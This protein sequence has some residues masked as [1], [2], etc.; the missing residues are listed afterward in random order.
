MRFLNDGRPLSA[1][2]AIRGVV[3]PDLAAAANGRSIMAPTPL[4]ASR[5]VVQIL[6]EQ[7]EMGIYDFVNDVYTKVDP[8][9]D[10]YAA[11]DENGVNVPPTGRGFDRIFAGGGVWA[12]NAIGA[13]RAR[14]VTDSLGRHWGPW[15]AAVAV[16]ATGQVLIT[17]RVL[18][19]GTSG[20]DGNSPVELWIFEPGDRADA[21][22]CRIAGGFDAQMVGSLVLW[23]DQNSAWHA[24]NTG[25]DGTLAGPRPDP[26][27][28]GALLVLSDGRKF[29]L[30]SSFG[31]DLGEWTD[32]SVVADGAVYSDGP[33]DF[34]PD[35]RE[36]APGVIEVATS[37]GAGENDDEWR[38]TRVIV[39]PPGA[40]ATSWTA[41]RTT[42]AGTG[43]AAAAWIGDIS[44]PP[45]PPDAP[46]S[47]IGSLGGP[48][49]IAY[50]EAITPAMHYGSIDLPTNAQYLSGMSFSDLF[51]P[52]PV[53][54]GVTE[55]ASVPDEFLIAIT[56]AISEGGSATDLGALNVA[57]DY[58]VSRRKPLALL[59]DAA[60]YCDRP[61]LVAIVQSLARP[62]LVVWFW[63]E[64]YALPGASRA[65][66]AARWDEESA[67]LTAL[68]VDFIVSGTAYTQTRPRA[69]GTPDPTV[70]YPLQL[71][72]DLQGDLADHHRKYIAAG[73]LKADLKFAGKRFGGLTTYPALMATVPQWAAS[74]T[75][76]TI[77]PVQSSSP[78]QPVSEDDNM[79]LQQLN[80]YEEGCA[81]IDLAV[82]YVW[83]NGN[84]DM[85][86][87]EKRRLA[88][89]YDNKFYSRD[90]V[91]ADLL[92]N[93][94]KWTP[95]LGAGTAGAPQ[96]AGKTVAQIVA[97]LPK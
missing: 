81:D 27:I 4:D 65:D 23:K 71:I 64:R 75:T 76:P 29:L 88:G 3:P 48:L 30:S 40:P 21:P 13:G 69:D 63:S 73:R 66:I 56:G 17:T 33:H 7:S 92:S 86:R 59:L 44:A 54:A 38:I 8:Q 97:G 49:W 20:D 41:T 32:G 2:G 47:A 1:H 24:Y 42:P 26:P 83:P 61:D 94:A 34:N 19:D 96:C 58:A 18:P 10:F 50:M 31:V 60:R 37:Y 25:A 35:F 93:N 62:G 90:E 79:T 43:D 36:A 28:G 6:D 70:G 95:A 51:R 85:A 89:I 9:P 22:S 14:G 55:A 78:A 80:A 5:I 53:F 74:V 87:F 82:K 16:T 11:T 39:G 77:A 91:V 46:V 84:D 12:A 15:A 57:A 67:F 72:L 68:G 52:G 45:A